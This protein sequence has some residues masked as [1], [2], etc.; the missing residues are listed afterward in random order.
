MINL[1]LEIGSVDNE[2]RINEIV[3]AVRRELAWTNLLAGR[4]VD[5][6]S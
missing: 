6:I 1:N 5:D 3:E 4:N 2:D